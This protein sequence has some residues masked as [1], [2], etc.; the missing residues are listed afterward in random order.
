MERIA[1]KKKI[2]VRKYAKRSLLTSSFYLFCLT[3]WQ[4]LVFVQ[5]K[6]NDDEVP[7]ML[8]LFLMIFAI[9]FLCYFEIRTI[10]NN[11]ER[12]LGYKSYILFFIKLLFIPITVLITLL[13]GLKTDRIIYPILA[14]CG[15]VIIYYICFVSCIYPYKKHIKQNTGELYI[16][17]QTRV[18]KWY[19]EGTIE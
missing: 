16:S 4:I 2:T 10:T 12:F 8:A 19:V 18:K 5:N 13:I 9:W 14:N 1:K 6:N 11:E 7:W 17:Y 15:I 3:V